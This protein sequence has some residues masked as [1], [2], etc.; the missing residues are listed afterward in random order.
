MVAPIRI[1]SMFSFV[2]KATA[3]AVLPLI[4]GE[5]AANSMAL[6]AVA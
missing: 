4:F 5:A 1:G 2:A 6:M 3:T